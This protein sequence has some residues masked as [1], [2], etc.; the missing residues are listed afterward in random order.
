MTTQ[1]AQFTDTASSSQ[2]LPSGSI[3]EFKDYPVQSK[4][5]KHVQDLPILR[6]VFDLEGVDLS[7][8]SY[9]GWGVL[10]SLSGALFTFRIQVGAHCF[11][12]IANPAD[13][14]LWEAIDRWEKAGV[15]VMAAEGQDGQVVLVS[16]DFRLDNPRFSQKRALTKHSD[17]MT[18]TYVRT[19]MENYRDGM[20]SRLGSSDIPRFPELQ[21]VQV[22]FLE[23]PQTKNMPLEPAEAKNTRGENKPSI[24]QQEHLHTFGSSA[25][26]FH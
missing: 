6:G 25:A 5:P 9:M 17:E 8:Q 13:K 22:C 26:R 21:R 18:A 11:Y 3:I 12:M 7:E 1:S 2:L 23:T 14:F 16:R 19:T 24:V 15:I 4:Q 10:P 20:F